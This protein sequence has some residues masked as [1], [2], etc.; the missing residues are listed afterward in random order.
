MQQD[1][2]ENIDCLQRNQN[3]FYK[4]FS[5]KLKQMDRT[6]ELKQK[7]MDRIEAMLIEDR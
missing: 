4:H 7:Q 1:V 6:A 3:R 2:S 5:S